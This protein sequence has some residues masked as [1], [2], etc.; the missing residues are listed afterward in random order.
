M[1]TPVGVDERAALRWLQRDIDE[2]S[3]APSPKLPSPLISNLLQTAMI[4]L[5]SRAFFETLAAA[6]RRSRDQ[7]A[8]FFDIPHTQKPHAMTSPSYLRPWPEAGLGW[9]A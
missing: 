9:G 1:P 2:R 6:R 4:A 8:R 5:R 7:R 3:P